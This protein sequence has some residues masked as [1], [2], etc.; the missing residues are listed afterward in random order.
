M[1]GDILDDFFLLVHIALRT[2]MMLLLQSWLRKTDRENRPWE[3]RGQ[4][5]LRAAV[6]LSSWGKKREGEGGA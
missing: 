4:G 5:A 3:G 1:K 6:I 2:A